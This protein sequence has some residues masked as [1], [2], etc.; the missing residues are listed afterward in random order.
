MYERPELRRFGSLREL[1]EAGWDGDS[2]GWYFRIAPTVSG[3]ADCSLL[4]RNCS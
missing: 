2:D 3:N 1:T 4:G